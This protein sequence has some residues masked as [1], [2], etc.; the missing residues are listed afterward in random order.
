MD[1]LCLSGEGSKV[2]KTAMESYKREKEIMN[3]KA[4]ATGNIFRAAITDLK[5]GAAA[6]HFETMIFFLACWQYRS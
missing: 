5:L 2:H 4:S 3:R 1:H 6:R